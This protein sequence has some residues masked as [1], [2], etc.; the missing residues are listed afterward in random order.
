MRFAKIV[1]GLVLAACAGRTDVFGPGT[2]PK[3]GA[4]RDSK[5]QIVAVTRLIAAPPK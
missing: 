3:D 4:L 2:G 5:N 1:S